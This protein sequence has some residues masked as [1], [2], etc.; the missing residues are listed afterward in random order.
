MSFLEIKT[1]DKFSS[2]AFEVHPKFAYLEA[3]KYYLLSAFSSEASRFFLISILYRIKREPEL[4]K[5]AVFEIKSPC[6]HKN[7]FCL[8]IRTVF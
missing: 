6:L 4:M 7:K 1:V 2:C 5:K 3:Y 8:S